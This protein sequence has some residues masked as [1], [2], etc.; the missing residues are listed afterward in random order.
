MFPR[1]YVFLFFASLLHFAGVYFQVTSKD[2]MNGRKK[3]LLNLFD[4]LLVFRI[5][6]WKLLCLGTLKA[7]PIAF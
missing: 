1:F 7:W 5:L 6:D 4:S 3:F 2:R